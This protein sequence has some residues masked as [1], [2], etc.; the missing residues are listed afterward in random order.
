MELT[1]LFFAFALANL[2]GKIFSKLSSVAISSNPKIMYT[3][4]FVINGLTA[5]IFFLASS[6]FNVA[7]NTATAVYSLV[8]SLVVL[9]SILS[10]YGIYKFISV[11][12]VNVITNASALVG[13]SLISILLFDEPIALTSILKV[14]IMLVAVS[15]IFVD[16]KKEE[17]ASAT[18]LQ[19]P[20]LK[21]L[22]P[23]LLIL[24]S[25][26]CLNI[27]ILKYFSNSQYVTNETSFFFFTNVIL[28]V[29]ALIVLFSLALKDG[30]AV[31]NTVKTLKPKTVV[32]M[33]GSTVCSN[34]ISILGVWII[35]KIDVSL[36]T[37]LSSALGIIAGVVGSMILREKL[38]VFSY[39]AMICAIMAIII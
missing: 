4:L 36:Y 33:A 8:Y 32:T 37:A 5:C 16:S 20:S 35:A 25:T 39:F 26:E 23:L 11:A 38:G 19:K 6:G 14:V 13:L 17:K 3:V 30:K 21:K 34:V 7:L 15:F 2:F 24:V 28:I 29:T 1:I 31:L 27:V 10:S 9:F 22:I 18:K 12:G